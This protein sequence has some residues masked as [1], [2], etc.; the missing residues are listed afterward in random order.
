MGK[1]RTDRGLAHPGETHHAED[2][3]GPKT[4]R[5]FIDQLQS[6]SASGDDEER[7][8]RPR[9]GRHRLAENREQHDKP[10]QNAEANRMRRAV[11]RGDLDPDLPG[12]SDRLKGDA[13]H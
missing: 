8:A 10:D 5:A 9:A 4:R 12:V 1:R 3:H 2:A 7:V 13:G 6:G 11:Q